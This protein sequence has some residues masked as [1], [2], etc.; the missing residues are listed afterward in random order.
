MTPLIPCNIPRLPDTLDSIRGHHPALWLRSNKTIPMYSWIR[1]FLKQHN[2]IRSCG[3]Y[4]Q[5]RRCDTSRGTQGTRRLHT[6]HETVSFQSLQVYIEPRLIVTTKLSPPTVSGT[7][8]G[9]TLFRRTC[10][11]VCHRSGDPTGLTVV[12]CCSCVGQG[13]AR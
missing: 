9:S 8:Y 13:Q 1:N 6:S 4:S 10:I 11:H 2:W 12:G 3:T 5:S 7:F